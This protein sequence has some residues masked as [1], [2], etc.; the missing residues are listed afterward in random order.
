MGGSIFRRYCRSLAPPAMIFN[1]ARLKTS[2][3]KRRKKASL[4]NAGAISKIALPNILFSNLFLLAMCI[5]FGVSAV[6]TLFIA[7]SAGTITVLAGMLCKF[8]GP[9]ERKN[10]KWAVFSFALNSLAITLVWFAGSMGLIRL[11]GGFPGSSGHSFAAIG[12]AAQQAIERFMALLPMIAASFIPRLATL[13]VETIR[14]PEDT[15]AE[16]EVIEDSSNEI[17]ATWMVMMFGFVWLMVFGVPYF[18]LSFIISTIFNYDILQYANAFNAAA[19]ISAKIAIEYWF[20]LQMRP[21][22]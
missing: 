15:K 12:D 11:D 7:F 21:G 20:A 1:D 10:A 4:G 2:M 19:I 18:A 5:C 17:A 3:A 9:K 16:D 14:A 22:K 8:A 13:A 6:D